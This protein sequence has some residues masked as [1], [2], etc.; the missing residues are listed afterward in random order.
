ME[1]ST[2][3]KKKEV[4]YKFWPDDLQNRFKKQIQ[5]KKHGIVAFWCAYIHIHKPTSISVNFFFNIYNE[6]G[7]IIWVV[8][9]QK[10]EKWH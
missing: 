6:N 10:G 1:Y 7:Y 3:L 4:N 5:N 9:G 2:V 8:D